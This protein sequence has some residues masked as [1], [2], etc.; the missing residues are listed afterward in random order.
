MKVEAKREI[1]IVNQRGANELVA[2]KWT[3]HREA[4]LPSREVLRADCLEAIHARLPAGL[5]RQER[6]PHMSERVLE[7]WS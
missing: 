3:L 2:R 5:T 7:V 1:W 4:Y 6:A